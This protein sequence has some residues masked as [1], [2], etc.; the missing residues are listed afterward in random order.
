[1]A[2]LETVV[3]ILAFLLG[4]AAILATLSSAVRTFVLPRSDNVWLTRIVFLNVRKILTAW[5]RWRSIDTYEGRD[6]I[7]AFLA[8]FT[9]L[10]LPVVWLFYI[11]IA[12]MFVF[13]AMGVR[14]WS[15]AFMLSGSSML[16]LGTVPFSD[17]M[18]AAVEF[19][20]AILGLGMVALL[21]AYLPTMYSAFSKRET[22][23]TMLEVRAGSPPSAVEMIK[24]SHR[25]RGLGYLHEMWET[26]EF[27]FAELEESHTSLAPLI[28]FRSPQAERSWVTAAGAVLD[29]AALTVSTVDIPADAQAQLCIRAGYLALRKIGD[30][31][32]LEYNA[33]PRFPDDPIS[34]TQGEFNEA[35]NELAAAGVPLKP[36]REQCWRDFAGWRVNYDAVLLA[37]AALTM[38]PYA[39]WS[40]DRSM[41][42]PSPAFRS[43]MRQ[44]NNSKVKVAP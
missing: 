17:P 39:P 25:I 8:P 34:I 22:A 2:L 18:V 33:D 24:R 20:E 4:V 13:W 32:E 26:W 3:R 43:R 41:L 38:A 7:M 29:A 35:Y 44:H 21:M 15:N 5:I 27:W 37:L 19:S 30:F 6:H 42:V 31:F 16:T 14:P 40:S 36:D 12:Y 9:L 28:F 1:M 11:L 10:L 23:V